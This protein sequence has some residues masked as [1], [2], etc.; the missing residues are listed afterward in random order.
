MSFY[1]LLTTKSA[2]SVSGVEYML[3]SDLEAAELGDVF[4]T[5]E[6]RHED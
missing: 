3:E 1:Q 6:G 4:D 2:V 5:I